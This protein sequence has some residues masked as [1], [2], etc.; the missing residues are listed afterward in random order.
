MGFKVTPF[1]RADEKMHPHKQHAG[2]AVPPLIPEYDKV[3][4]MLLSNAPELDGKNK[5]VTPLPNIPKGSKLL[6]TEAKGGQ[7]D[8]T[9]NMYVF[10]I[11]HGHVKFVKVAKSLWHPFD[12]LRHLPEFLTRAIYNVLHSSKVDTAK[13]RLETLQTWR[14]WA[15]ELTDKE[16]ELKRNMPSHVRC[17]M[18]GKRLCLLNKIAC[19]L[20][21]WPDK[22]LF[23][24]L[25]KGFRIVGEAPATGVFRN[26]PRPGNL[27]EGE[28]M[29]QSKFLRPAIIGKT[30]STSTGSHDKELFDI[31]IKEATEKA[32][33]RGP[34]DHD[35]VCKA[36]GNDWLPVRRFCVEQKGKLRPIDDFCENR[37][38][39]AF[40]SVDKISL[41]TM[42]HITWAVLVI[43]KHAIHNHEMDFV[44]KSGERLRGKVHEDWTGGCSLSA[45]T[46]DLQSAYKQLPLHEADVNKAVVTLRDPACNVARHFTMCT[47]PFG[48][49]ASVLHFNRVS[50]LLWAV[51]C[52]LNIVWSSYFDDYPVL[53]PEG[54]EK[55]TL[56]SAKTLLGLLG[57]NYSS[58]KLKDPSPRSEMLGVELDLTESK[59]GCVSIGNKQDRIADIS[60]TLDKIILDGRLRPKDLQSHLGR[61]QFAEMQIAGRAGRLAMADLRQL[62]TTDSSAVSWARARSTPWKFSGKE[63]RP[64][65]LEG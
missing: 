38:N 10:G 21:D 37:V 40:S 49:S 53:C 47:L 9:F 20:L 52:Y 36:V 17:V 6:R 12:E 41:K 45:T 58:E 14:R 15:D 51:G 1:P 13:Q 2:R 54:R 43:C 33:L 34:M 42:D 59:M 8:K 30:N 22:N 4:S 19:E 5:L 11:F 35:E 16:T 56:G 23:S 31:T 63:Y 65:S 24:D 7:G 64:A 3:V 18:E 27:S 60:A 32:W 28:L 39:Q 57:F 61:F 44:L 48:A 62:G 46:L 25:C 50:T 55:S 26:Q 29:K